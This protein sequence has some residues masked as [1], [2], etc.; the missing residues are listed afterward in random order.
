MK[1]KCIFVALLL[2]LL[3]VTGCLNKDAKLG[4]YLDLNAK[5]IFIV[6]IDGLSPNLINEVDHPNI[7][8]LIKN[9]SC[10]FEAQTVFP[11]KTLP[12]HASM[13]SGL[14][15]E[16]HG[17]TWNDRNPTKGY[18]KS[19][20][21]FSVTKGNKFTNLA[22][23]E[24]NKLLHILPPRIVDVV[25]IN[26][27]SLLTIRK[28]T[29]SFQKYRPSVFF[30][31]FAEVDGAGHRH[32]WGSKE[33]KNA[34]TK[35][36]LALGILIETLKNNNSLENSIIMVTADH[37]GHG[38]NHGENIPEDMTIPWIAY[39]GKIKKDYKIKSGVFV[40]DTAPTALQFLGL[41]VPQEWDGKPIVEIFEN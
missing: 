15:V 28:A 4:R 39:G 23:I 12:A 5:H 21:V 36:D 13:I 25:S 40:Y 31:H 20:T 6:S 26:F 1:K 29:A 32:G 41:P 10:T 35:I 18:I 22:F 14:K 38:K 19:K 34:L 7:E 30:I 17:I 24:K 9:G 16:H 37:G 27:R 11:S 8:Y 33:Q 2:S 3:I